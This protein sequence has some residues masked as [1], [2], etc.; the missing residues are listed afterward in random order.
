ME[1][2]KLRNPEIAAI[3]AAKFH[4]RN[5]HIQIEDL[6]QEALRALWRAESCG[7]YDPHLSSLATFSTTVATRSLLTYVGRQGRVGPITEELS[8]DLA[9]DR[10]DPEHAAIFGEMIRQLPEDARTVVRLVLGDSA[11][12][13]GVS[14]GEARRVIGEALGWPARRLADAFSVIEAALRSSGH[15]F[16]RQA[17]VTEG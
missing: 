12:F 17:P 1:T 5:T 14:S 2:R 9:D 13:G 6:E 8:D 3:V 11:S 7:R 15:G 16:F 10:P 4:R